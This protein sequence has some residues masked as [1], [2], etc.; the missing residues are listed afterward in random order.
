MPRVTFSS[1]VLITLVACSSTATGVGNPS[2]PPPPPAPAPPPSPPPPPPPPPPSPAEYHT[3]NS[4]LVWDTGVL[5]VHDSARNRD[6]LV[7]GDFPL[8]APQPLPVVL[9]SPSGDVQPDGHVQDEAWGITLASAGFAVIHLSA[10]DIAS[11]AYCSDFQVPPAECEPSD[12]NRQVA[13]GGTLAAIWIARPRDASAVLDQLGFVAN[14]IGVQL[15]QSRVAVAGWSGGAYTVMMLAG[16]R[17]DISP[18]VTGV[19]TSDRRFVAYLANSPIGIGRGGLTGTS[20]EGITKPVL[21]QT[22]AND[23]ASFSGPADRRNVYFLMPPGDK[24]EAYFA[25]PQATHVTF[26]LTAFGDAALGVFIGRDGVAFFDAYVRGLPA[27]RIWLS[28]NQL[29]IWSAGIGQMSA[30]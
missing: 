15:D 1:V 24:Y 2:P 12:F 16:A 22:G 19:S 30:K 25:S 3:P 5:I 8:G 29:G 14:Q 7:R 21:T 27:A 17:V 4:Y 6:I 11:A 23:I 10:P 18:S 9:I 20:W 28:T 26:G 13:V